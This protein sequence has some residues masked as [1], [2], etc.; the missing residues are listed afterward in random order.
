[1]SVIDVPWVSDDEPREHSY[2]ESYTIDDWTFER[3]EYILEVPYIQVTVLSYDPWEASFCSDTGQLVVRITHHV[4]WN[5]K[6]KWLSRICVEI[7][8]DVHPEDMRLV[9]NFTSGI[10]SY[11]R[12]EVRDGRWILRLRHRDHGPWWDLIADLCRA[13][14][15]L[16][17]SRW[18]ERWDRMKF[19]CCCERA[20]QIQDA[21]CL[22]PDLAQRIAERELAGQRLRSA[23]MIVIFYLLHPKCCNMLQIILEQGGLSRNNILD[24]LDRSL[25][26]SGSMVDTLPDEQIRRYYTDFPGRGSRAYIPTIILKH[27]RIETSYLNGRLNDTNFLPSYRHDDVWF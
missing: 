17:E 8:P 27:F 14:I 25:M 6:L 22:P 26:R 11:K 20:E 24:L 15:A 21:L 10:E 1:M 7:P 9:S 4:P 12:I 19:L 5:P 23:S 2:C 3:Y 18:I 13:G 16:E